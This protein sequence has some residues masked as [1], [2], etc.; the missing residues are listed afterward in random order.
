MPACSARSELGVDTAEVSLY[1]VLGEEQ[2]ARQFFVGLTGSYELQ[3][4][5]LTR[6]Q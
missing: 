3:D 2:R 4:L 5:Q 1:R 6:S